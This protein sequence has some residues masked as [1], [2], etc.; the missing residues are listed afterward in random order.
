MEKFAMIVSLPSSAVDAFEKELLEVNPSAKLYEALV[1]GIHCQEEA[2]MVDVPGGASELLA[3]YQ[4]FTAS[5]DC[6]Y[7]FTLPVKMVSQHSSADRICSFSIKFEPDKAEN[8]L[9]E[10][11]S[12]CDEAAEALSDEEKKLMDYAIF[13]GEHR[14]IVSFQ[15][16]RPKGCDW[17]A[18]QSVI[19]AFCLKF[20]K[21]SV[22]H[23][24]AEMTSCTI[25]RNF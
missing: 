22:S 11:W 17:A 21:L 13:A 14:N 1:L 16:Y 24:R 12:M 10:L 19:V 8:A 15:A 25:M 2:R 4:H 3:I 6:P 20:M 5:Q 9:L 23:C 18:W 7:R